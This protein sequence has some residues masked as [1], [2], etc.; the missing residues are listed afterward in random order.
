MWCGAALSEV[1]CPRGHGLEEDNWVRY[2]A[3]KRGRL[4]EEVVSQIQ[5]LIEQRQLRPGDKLPPERELTKGFDVSRTVVREAV[6]SLEER[7]LVDVRHGSGVYVAEPSIDAVTESLA[8][9]LRVSESSLMPLLEVREILEV[10]IAG[11]AAERATQE[12]QEQM[13]RSL[14]HEAGLFDSRDEYVEADLEFHELLTRATHN[15][16]LPILLKPLAELLRESRRVTI[17]PP[18]STELSLAGHREIFEAVK[19]GDR[20]QARE[21][22]REHLRMVKK[23]LGRT[24]Y[25]EDG[26]IGAA[27]KWLG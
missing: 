8:L 1:T 23:M 5:E 12:D 25:V 11:L 9:H 26:T 17:E 10:E 24:G 14:R 18:G 13:E 7:G 20:E 2:R 16:V 4:H 21:A 3:A 27:K 15:E 6:R 19:N 22:M